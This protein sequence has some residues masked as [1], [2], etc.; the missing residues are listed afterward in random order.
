MLDFNKKDVEFLV[1]YSKG[2]DVL[3]FFIKGGELF[4]KGNLLNE[5]CEICGN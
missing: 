4:G 5:K 2:L 3:V 1:M